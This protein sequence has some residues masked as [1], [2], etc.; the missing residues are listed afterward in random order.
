MPPFQLFNLINKETNEK[1][2]WNKFVF[3]T[4]KSIILWEYKQLNEKI[5]NVD[6]FSTILYVSDIY[7]ENILSIISSKETREIYKVEEDLK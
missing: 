1:D 2:S 7:E 4:E 3:L 5:R 6:K